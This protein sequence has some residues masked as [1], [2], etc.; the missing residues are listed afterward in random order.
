MSNPNIRTIHITKLVQMVF[1]SQFGYFEYVGHVLHG[2]TLEG[3]FSVK[4]S[5]WLLSTS[6]VLFQPWQNLSSEKSPA[7]N[8]ASHFDTSVSRSTFSIHC[9]NL[10]LHFSCILTFLE[11]IKD[12]MQKML[13][14]STL[15]LIW[16]HKNSIVFIFLMHTDM[17]AV[18]KQS[19][20]IISN[21]IKDSQALLEPS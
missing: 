10:T 15:I 3:F 5:V 18:T 2:I 7:Q 4:V 13:L 21:E 6:T 20:K 16:L 19:Y 9:T 12:D 17:T 8:F 11:I 1:S 14:F